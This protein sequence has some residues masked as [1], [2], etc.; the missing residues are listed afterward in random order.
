MGCNAKNT[1]DFTP[2]P[3]IK[4][5]TTP[6]TYRYG[7][8]AGKY[9][10]SMEVNKIYENERLSSSV[11]MHFDITE[12]LGPLL[13]KISVTKMTENGETI[14]PPK[15]IF[16]MQMGTDT[17]GVPITKMI[18]SSPWLES[19]PDGQKLADELM[20]QMEKGM[21][22]ISSPFAEGPIVSG[23]ALRSENIPTSKE[24]GLAEDTKMR[25]I[26]EGEFVRNGILYVSGIIDES[27]KTR[28]EGKPIVITVTGTTIMEKESMKSTEGEMIIGISKT[29]GTMLATITATLIEGYDL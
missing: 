25:L 22:D 2:R 18:M 11:E 17:R 24:L 29:D 27:F 10:V 4:P 14:A 21:E 12:E 20:K 13:W 16:N 1:P 9:L 26:L 23:Q 19:I 15:P 8:A 6:T 3:G 5:V 28:I 7:P